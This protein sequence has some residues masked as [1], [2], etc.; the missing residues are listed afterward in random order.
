MKKYN[1]EELLAGEIDLTE[2]PPIRFA[3]VQVPMIQRDY[4]QGRE[5][6]AAVRQRF[7]TALFGALTG[8]HPLTLDFVY[9]SVQT[10][11]GEAY[12][13]PLDGQQR[14]TTLFLLHWY[15]GNR[16]LTGDV[17]RELAARLR[18]FSYATRSTA[19]EF[20]EQLTSVELAPTD[21]PGPTIRNLTWF[22][23]SYAQDPTVQAMLRMLDAMHDKYRDCGSTSLY[24]ALEGL[25]FYVLP[26]DGFGLSDE[27]YIK[28]NARGKQLTGF[29][30]FKADLLNWL[31]DEANPY[32]AEFDQPTHVAAQPMPYHLALATKLDTT[33]TQLLW[34][35]GY[36]QGQLDTAYLRFWNR[37]L[38]AR[39]FSEPRPVPELANRLAGFDRGQEVA[40]YVGFTHYQ[41][42]FAKPGT[43]AAAERLLDGLVAHY[44]IIRQIIA[45]TWGEQAADWH[46]LAQSINQRQRL[47]FFAVMRYL[48]TPGFEEESLR[49]W[50]RVIWNLGIDPDVRST[51]NMLVVMRVI[52]RLAPGAHDIY[53]F[54]A[55]AD[56]AAIVRR[57]RS[58]VQALLQEERQKA[59]LILTDAAWEAALIKAEKH[60]LFRGNVGF[61][62]LNAPALP[63]FQHR[64]ASASALFSAKGTQGAFAENHLLLRA[65]ISEAPT[66][67]W[68]QDLNRADGEDNWRLLLRRDEVVRAA[69]GQVVSLTTPEAMHQHLLQLVSRPSSLVKGSQPRSRRSFVHEQLYQAADLQGWLQSVGATGIKEK[70][71][72][73][74]AYRYFGRD[75]TRVMLDT[76]RN[77]IAT[78]LIEQL[79]FDTSQRCGTS[80]YFWGDELT[81]QRQEVNWTVTAA[82]DPYATLRIGIRRAEAADF[83]T[84]DLATAAEQ[85]EHWL[86]LKEYPYADLATAVQ[87]QALVEQVREELFETD[88]FAA[89]L[90][91]RPTASA[92]VG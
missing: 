59:E 6:E 56:G 48:D 75:Y 90:T 50:L 34:G 71:W 66:W 16:E 55:S 62:L 2:Q 68:L 70:D 28:M 57:E 5:T 41:T 42:L 31:R 85:S 21:R 18:K 74:Y 83:D 80:S 76:Y 89:R 49:R 81:L 61:L 15:I 14:L 69:I 19:R 44:S 39:Y 45:E 1:L 29:E 37:F 33:W 82:F 53:A 11:D 54:L 12:F 78:A 47:L 7:L 17:R 38:A 77:A 26:L 25:R 67:Q 92:S 22:Y 79:G 10:L 86:L 65:V 63:V 24:P 91:V 36:K 73:I 9:G 88:F 35:L 40:E 20:C 4:A 87:A 52:E 58:F 32:R 13:V 60:G 51:E 46:L 27:L 23:G 8:G 30:N 3:G 43:I 64:L 72:R 84:T